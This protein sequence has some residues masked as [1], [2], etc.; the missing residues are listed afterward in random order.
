MKLS[1]EERRQLAR[2]RIAAVLQSRT[3]SSLR[4]L[5]N[6]ISDAGPNPQR[7]QPHALTPAKQELVK[8]GRIVVIASGNAQW[9]HLNDAD[10]AKVRERLSQVKEVWTGV[11][12]PAVVRRTGQAL[13]V[14]IYRAL[15]EAPPMNVIGGF[16]DLDGHD[17]SSLYS[18]H[19]IQ[20]L[21]GHSLGNEALDFIAHCNGHFI[22]I[23]AKNVRPWLYP[24]DPELRSA[25]RKA[26][27]L[28][29]IPV[30][31]ARRIPYVS[32]HVL[33]ACG[34]IM[35]ETYNQR[36]AQADEAVADQAKH[37]DLLGYH[38][39]RTGNVPD[40]RLTRFV[41]T[42]LPNLLNPAREKLNQFEDLL[43]PFA[44]GE[45]PYTEFAAR[46]RRRQAGQNEDSDWEQD[47]DEYNGQ[48]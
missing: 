48:T 43:W 24:H 34:V 39:I 22:G 44:T 28:G 21:N 5:E 2:K 23:E 1:Q 10:P 27:T 25:I 7:I 36:M 35:H 18:K 37:K 40:A 16:D 42:N 46:V 9:L 14:A 33:G 45:M 31:I 29:T 32:F 26:L 41:S 38:D 4:T 17:D 20:R 8:E 11:T 3:V 15:L 13:E 19:E 47:G 6:K 30:I 12:N